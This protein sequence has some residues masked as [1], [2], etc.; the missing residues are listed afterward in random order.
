MANIKIDGKDYDFDKLSDD[1]KSQL[2]A[3]QFVDAE[4]TRLSSQNAAMQTARLAYA[5][6]LKDGLAAS[7]AQVN[8]ALAGDT[9]K[10]S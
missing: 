10:F 6:A 8:S 4:L 3:L 5:K 2:A 7:A 9:I 1:T